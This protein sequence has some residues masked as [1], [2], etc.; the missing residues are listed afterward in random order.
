MLSLKAI[1]VAVTDFRSKPAYPL[2]EAARILRM[3]PSTLRTRFALWPPRRASESSYL[4]F[5]ELLEGYMIQVLRRK[6]RL[7]LQRIRRALTYLRAKTQ[8]QYPLAMRGEDIR[9]DGLQIF[10]SHLGALTSASENGQGAI[11]EVLAKFL[12][13]IDRDSTGLALRFYPF[14]R[15][16]PEDSPKFI[17]IDPALNFGRPSIA[18]MGIPTA[19]IAARFMAGEEESDLAA[20]YNC[21]L[22]QV[23][24]AIRIES[25]LAQVAA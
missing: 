6:Y 19:I 22:R 17:V 11:P 23:S 14:T 7:P 25:A 2:H 12:Q 9:T 8:L 10:I 18:G 21:E 15:E 3:P 13:R 1:V 20:D 24:E 16:N 5:F 4:N